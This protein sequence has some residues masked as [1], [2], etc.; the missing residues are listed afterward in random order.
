VAEPFLEVK[1]GNFSF[2]NAE[3]IK[4]ALQLHKTFFENFT[5]K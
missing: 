1:D 2:Y 5:S 4:V 3:E